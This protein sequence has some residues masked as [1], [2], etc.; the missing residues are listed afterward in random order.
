MQSSFQIQLVPQG[1]I[2]HAHAGQGLLEVLAESGVFLRSDCGGKGTCQKCRVKVDG[3]SQRAC[4]VRVDKNLS[5]EIPDSSRVT[6]EVTVKPPVTNKQLCDLQSAGT[7]YGLA[8]DLGTTTMA[9]YLCDLAAGRVAASVSVRNPQFSSGMDVISRIAQAG[10]SRQ[11]RERL[12][13]I[14]VRAIEWGMNSLPESS[15]IK[16]MLV[17]GNP[18]MLHL[19][20]GENPGSLGVSPFQPAF[21]EARMVQAASLGFSANMQVTSLPLVS[22]FVGSDIV[23]AA[24]AVG[25]PD[26]EAGSLLV[27]IG[28]NG[29]IMLR[30]QEGLLASS[31][32]TG[33]AF[34][35]ASLKYG[36]PAVS[37]AIEAVRI[38]RRE[39]VRD[40][41]AL[42]RHLATV[43]ALDLLRMRS[44]QRCRCSAEADLAQAISREPNPTGHAEASELAS[45]ALFLASEASSYITGHALA[46]D[47]GMLA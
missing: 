32:A 11:D 43:R 23:A 15:G 6:P 29:E 13:R 2:L 46:V 10:R 36:M 47:G 9:L 19:F 12:Q 5:V 20:L 24:L 7:G 25:L 3:V 38:D 37:G 4:G 34:E 26:A 40:W 16:R 45:A 18:A 28:T 8:L 30:T 33:P 1:E 44:R 41:P 22:G 39:P 27:D 42:L 17:V 31:C 35:G 14:V 21:C